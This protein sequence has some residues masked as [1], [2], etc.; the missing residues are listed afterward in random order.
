MMHRLKRE[1][2]LNGISNPRMSI[3]YHATKSEDIYKKIVL[4]DF[5]MMADAATARLYGNGV[6]AA[7]HP[8]INYCIG[9]VANNKVT[10]ASGLGPNNNY[11]VVIVANAVSRPS[12]YTNRG[13]WVQP[14]SRNFFTGGSVDDNGFDSSGNSVRPLPLSLDNR[15]VVFFQDSASNWSHIIGL[16]VFAIN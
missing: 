16:A 14:D 15:E 10:Y 7:I 8:Y 6:Y 12:Y 2:E 5:K 3:I 11:Y 9:G 1:K 13:T 4:G